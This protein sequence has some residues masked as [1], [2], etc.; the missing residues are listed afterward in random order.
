MKDN[1]KEQITMTWIL[2]LSLGSGYTNLTTM[3][4][5]DSPSS[6]MTGVV[7]NLARSIPARDWQVLLQLIIILACFLAGAALSGYLFRDRRM[8]QRNCYGCSLILAGVAVYLLKDRAFLFYGLIFLMGLQNAMFLVCRGTLIRTSHLTGYLSDIG[9]EIGSCLGKGKANWWK[10]YH[11]GLSILMFILGGF[12][13]V[14][15]HS[16]GIQLPILSLFYVLMGTSFLVM[17]RKAILRARQ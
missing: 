9:F 3:L 11:Y 6:H 14:C 4:L 12:L 8:V 2:L 16:Q 13:S 17:K 5:Y 1:R 7:S 15:F 10:I